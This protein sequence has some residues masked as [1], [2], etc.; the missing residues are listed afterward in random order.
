MKTFKTISIIAVV[1]VITILSCKKEEEKII[2]YNCTANMI[3][4]QTQ[5]NTTNFS[6]VDLF[7]N[8]EIE[9][10]NG[11]KITFSPN[12]FLNENGSGLIDVELIDVNENKDMLLM[13]CPTVTNLGELL[14]SGGIFYFNPTQDGN[15]LEINPANP[16]QVTMPA[17]NGNSMLYYE[18]VE[19]EDGRLSWQLITNNQIQTNSTVN[20]SGDTSYYYSFSLTGVGWINTDHPYGV[21]PFSSVQ[22]TLPDGHNGSNSSVF[23]YFR[24]ANACITAYDNG[25][26]V[27]ESPCTISEGEVVQFVVATAIEGVRKYCVTDPISIDQGIHSED[28]GS[29]ELINV[30]CD[31][32][33]RLS[34]KDALID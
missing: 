14:E 27:F 21:S 30:L 4:D 5:Q 3:A 16:P 1:L 32:A 19:D 9:G 18:G 8:P 11:T 15:Q 20:A 10:K 31:D 26:G 33:L 7:S 12:S 17:L 29:N 28:I 24:D 2:P 25:N 6:G 22:V 13:D 34:I 23:I